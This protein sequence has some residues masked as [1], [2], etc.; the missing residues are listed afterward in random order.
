MARRS[1]RPTIRRVETVRHGKRQRGAL[2]EIFTLRHDFRFGGFVAE[3]C[4]LGAQSLISDKARSADLDRFDR[5]TAVR[6]E[7]RLRNTGGRHKG[8]VLYLYLERQLVA[9][10]TFH[11]NERQVI[12]IRHAAS[13]AERENDR[14]IQ[15]RML[16]LQLDG[17]AVERPGDRARKPVHWRPMDAGQREFAHSLDFTKTQR[18][19]KGRQQPVLRR[20]GR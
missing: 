18:P 17:L 11:I 16:I 13:L 20:S 19:G 14:R 10:L 5:T 12:E 3:S 1:P 8:R 15:I 4:N 9:V 6:V 7:T 2:D